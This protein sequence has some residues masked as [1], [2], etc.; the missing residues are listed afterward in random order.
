MFVVDDLYVSWLISMGHYVMLAIY[1]TCANCVKI[2]SKCC[3]NAVK[4]LFKFCSCLIFV[5]FF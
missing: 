5:I 3:R 1:V 2:L 4:I